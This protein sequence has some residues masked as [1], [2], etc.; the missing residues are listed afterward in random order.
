MKRI[1]DQT[2]AA[3]TKACERIADGHQTYA[4]AEMWAD[5]FLSEANTEVTRGA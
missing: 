1:Y 5:R 4:T 2:R 3:L